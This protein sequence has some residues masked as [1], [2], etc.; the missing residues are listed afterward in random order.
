MGRPKERR[1]MILTTYKALAPICKG[2]RFARIG[3]MPA[4]T[5]AFAFCG[6]PK[7][8]ISIRNRKGEVVG[9]ASIET[10]FT[11]CNLK[12]GEI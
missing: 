10:N 8:S 11:E 3:K 9:G 7:M 4:D 5:F 6:H 2:C 12:K 1:D